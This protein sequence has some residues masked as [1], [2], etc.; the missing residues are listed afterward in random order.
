MK[1]IKVLYKGK[2]YKNYYQITATID[3]KRAANAKFV[4]IPEENR[5]WIME[6][7]VSEGRRGIN[8]GSMLLR[9]IDARA[10]EL[11]A[12]VIEA[13]FEPKGISKKSLE[14]FYNRNDFTVYNERIF[15]NLVEAN[16][17]EKI[18]EKRLSRYH[19]EIIHDMSDIEYEG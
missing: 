7:R 15:K 14:R 5:V 6:L 9:H 12:T 1:E 8:L 4:H 17:P 3:G 11:D 2:K 16:Q 19:N 10:R 13:Q 18:A